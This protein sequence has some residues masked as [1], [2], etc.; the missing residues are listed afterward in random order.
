MV[1]DCSEGGLWFIDIFEGSSPPTRFVRL[2]PSKLQ[3]G[4]FYYH[5][6]LNLDVNL[7]VPR[8]KIYNTDLGDFTFAEGYIW[9]ECA[10]DTA[11]GAFVN[12]E[13]W[14]LAVLDMAVKRGLLMAAKKKDSLR[15]IAK[16]RPPVTSMH[17]APAVW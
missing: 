13:R 12:S 2:A 11:N 1:T 5:G 8:Q 9:E 15:C 7:S 10:E 14:V 6:P 3:N 17:I 4:N 16:A